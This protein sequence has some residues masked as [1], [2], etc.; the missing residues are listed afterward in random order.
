M[1]P[2]QVRCQALISLDPFTNKWNL[3]CD[4]WYQQPALKILSCRGH[5][6][7]ELRTLKRLE[8]LNMAE[9]PCITDSSLLSL[10][11]VAS[12][13]VL[14]LDLCDKITDNGE[15]PCHSA[16]ALQGCNDA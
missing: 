10:S 2:H 5:T 16:H 14:N 7:G 12:I 4:I 6:L 9:C 8:T 15:L 11:E 1:S 3:C 13:R